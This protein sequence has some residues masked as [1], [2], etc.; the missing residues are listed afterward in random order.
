MNIR[1]AVG[2]PVKLNAFILVKRNYIC[3]AAVS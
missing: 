1:Q 2:V 3:A